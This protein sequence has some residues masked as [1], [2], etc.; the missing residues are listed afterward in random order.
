[1][2]SGSNGAHE[3]GQWKREMV[4]SAPEAR[5]RRCLI[6][7]QGT[8]PLKPPAPFPSGSMF[9]NG[10][11]LSRVRKPR[12]NRAPLTDFFRSESATGMRERGPLGGPPCV[13]ASRWRVR[14]HKTV[15]N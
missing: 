10:R 3:D 9:Q 8:S 12:T 7:R 2:D 4:G 6:L 5:M 14:N 13:P 11:N 1:M 15:D